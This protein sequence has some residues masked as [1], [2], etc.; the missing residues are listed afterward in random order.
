MRRYLMWIAFSWGV[1][2][3][4]QAAPAVAIPVFARIYD[5]PCGT[6]HTVF[7]QLNPYTHRLWSNRTWITGGTGAT[8]RGGA[9]PHGTCDDQPTLGEPQ[10]GGEL[11]AVYPE[12]GVTLAGG[13]TNG[14]NNR[15]DT[16]GS[17]NGYV[18]A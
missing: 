14:S 18:H 8:L 2:C 6:C 13:I 12:R 9:P 11:S 16:V 3:A 4:L 5:K 7:P 10:I 17:P 15:L 1:L